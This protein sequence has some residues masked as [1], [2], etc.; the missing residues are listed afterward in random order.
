[1]IKGILGKKLGMSQIF[2]ENGDIVPVTLIQA[3]PCFV[4]QKKMKEK[5]GYDAIQLGFEP[6]KENRVNSPLKGHQNKAGKGYFH[7]LRELLCDDMDSF[8]IGQ[9]IKA[10]DIF[11]KGEKIKITGTSKGKGFAGVTKRH[12]FGGLPASH[13]SLIHRATGSIGCSADPSK[14]IKGKRMPGHM[15]N[16]KVTVKSLEVV[17]V[18]SDD[19]VIAIK[20]AVPGP[21]GQVVVLKKQG[22]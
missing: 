1:M 7:Y 10:S 8:E 20:G 11:E 15:G 14:V 19:N 18:M 17:D 21:K 2:N 3:G 5:D 6:K 4:I 13:G 9:E 12:G 16:R 22:V